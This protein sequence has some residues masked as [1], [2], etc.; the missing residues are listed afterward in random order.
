M[1][2]EFSLPEPVLEVLSRLRGQG[3]EAFLVGGCVRDLLLRLAPSDW[4]VCTSAHPDAVKA[5]F[6]GCLETGL[7]HG[8]VT[9]LM[10]EPRQPG[11]HR[12]PVE[13]TTW[14]AESGYSDHRHP[15]VVRFSTTLGDD[16]SRRDFTINAMAWH[17]ETGLVDLFGGRDDLEAGIV[18]C[19]GD[20]IRRFREDALRM[21]RAVRFSSQ[22]GF[23]LDADAAKAVRH[24]RDDLV[25]VSRERI[26]YE[27]TRT[28]TG[29]APT[30][31]ALW[32][33]TGLHA[34]LFDLGGASPERF[35]GLPFTRL[36]QSLRSSGLQHVTRPTGRECDRAPHMGISPDAPHLPDGPDEDV[37]RWALFF[38]SCGMDS[39]E[40]VEQVALWMRLYRFPNNRQA[41]IR[42]LLRLADAPMPPTHRNLRYAALS[43]GPGWLHAA[44]ALRRYAG[45]ATSPDLHGM[46]VPGDFPDGAFVRASLA[47]GAT[48]CGSEFGALLDC[49]RMV[50]CEQPHLATPAV[51][52]VLASAMR[53]RAEAAFRASVPPRFWLDARI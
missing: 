46:I 38:R 51:L 43:E 25:H 44:F 23:V 13:I 42:K 17:P 14:R 53:D 16:L 50:P 7:R 27:M 34:L 48:P 52:S 8:T 30:R 12:M 45:G 10:P 4:D 49:L 21:L 11:G 9:A 3:H 36:E 32:W 41:G 33:D 47:G 29:I 5:L 15:D 28:L 19:V 37:L 35:D 40:R 24:R 31:A 39:A 1:I 2:S 26:Q 20:P 18:R 22:L 6:P